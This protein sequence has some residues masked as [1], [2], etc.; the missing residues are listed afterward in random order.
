MNT[1]TIGVQI[2][3]SVGGARK[4]SHDVIVIIRFGGRP[5][6]PAVEAAGLAMGHLVGGLTAP[7]ASPFLAVGASS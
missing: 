6:W 2:E 4:D 1:V 5:R 7:V 3:P